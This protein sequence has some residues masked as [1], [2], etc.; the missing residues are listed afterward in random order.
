M[1]FEPLIGH[2][3]AWLLFRTL[4]GYTVTTHEDTHKEG[5]RRR[6][7]LL[8]QHIWGTIRGYSLRRVGCLQPLL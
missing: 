8:V 4:P 5:L 1:H 7:T 2:D 3:F 6:S